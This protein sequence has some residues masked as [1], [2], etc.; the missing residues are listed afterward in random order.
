MLQF[1][2]HLCLAALLLVCLLKAGQFLRERLPLLRSLGLPASIV[3]GMI[4]LLLGPEVLGAI[5]TTQSRS[6][7]VLAN[8]LFPAP[9]RSIWENSPELA[10]N[11]VFAT[12]FLGQRIPS[13]RDIWQ[14][15]APQV[16]FGQ[17]LAW[18]QYVVGLSLT[19]FIL[20]PVFSVNPLAGTLIELAFEGGH[21][22]V[23]GMT[24]LLTDL[25]FPE[26]ADLGLGMATIG[27]VAAIVTGTGL[28]AWGR[29]SG[30]IQ[31][32]SPTSPIDGVSG[33]GL[34]G[35]THA[36]QIAAAATTTHPTP[37]GLVHL[38]RTLLLNLGLVGLSVLI[39]WLLLQGLIG[40]ESCTWGRSGLRLFVYMP[41]F[42]MALL[43]SIAVQIGMTAWQKEHW[44]D[45]LLIERIAAIA[46][47]VTIV[48]ALAS[49]SLRALGTHWL[50]FTVLALA[51]IG[52]N[53]LAFLYLAPRIIPSYWFERGIGD[54]G[55]SMGVTATGLLL[56][57]I[58][59]PDNRSGAFEGFACKQLLFEPI[60]GGG[61]FTALAPSLVIQFGPG[62]LLLITSG[63][64]V[65][66][67]LFGLMIGAQTTNRYRVILIRLFKPLLE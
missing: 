60:V 16:A 21:G 65:F 34:A 55:Q 63:I 64:L 9:L 44:L 51:G 46:L 14:K 67:L 48:T 18:G 35:D 25:G 10:I 36:T 37:E 41:L 59:D 43:G 33:E 26:G 15:A 47:D 45:R 50:A 5:A 1:F 3:A 11:L 13:L 38:S 58:V 39:G 49:I 40:L 62:T 57:Q 22:T 12:L 56:L 66:W 8:G 28:A 4:A 32:Q 2:A 29:R 6:D 42:P 31:T 54:L 53:L 24:Q 17:S 52:W 23:A 30:L 20:T 7:V 27:M 19:F 61:L